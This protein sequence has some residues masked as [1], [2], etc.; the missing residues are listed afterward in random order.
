MPV[1]DILYKWKG[2]YRTSPALIK[3]TLGTAYAFLPMRVRYGSFLQDYRKLLEASQWWSKEMHEEYQTKQLMALIVHAYENTPYYKDLF[4]NMGIKPYE[5][6]I[7]LIWEKIPL[8]NKDD[9]R[10]NSQKLV[11]QNLAGNLISAN[12]GGSTGEPLKLYWEKGRTRSL[13]RAFMWRQWEWAGFKYGSK[14]AVIRG[15]TVKEP[16]FHYDPI[17]KHLFINA[18][19]LT[20]K[21]MYAIV[22]KLNQFCPKSIQAYPSTLTIFAL[23]MKENKVRLKPSLKVLLCGSENLYPAQKDLFAETF[24]VRVYNWY[25]HGESCCMAGYCDKAD[26]YHV[27][28]E[29]G[30]VELVNESGK[31]VE[32]KEGNVGEIVA[33][34]FINS[35]MPLIRYRTGDIAMVGP[36]RCVCGRNYPLLKKIQGRKQEYVITSDGRA[37]SLTGL[38][39]GQHWHAFTKITKLQFEQREAGNVLIR[40]IKRDNYTQ[41]DENEIQAKIAS[42]TNNSLAVSFDYVDCIEPTP[43]GKHIFVKQML[44]NITEW[45]GQVNEIDAN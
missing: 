12:T 7:K 17:D 6:D 2:Q 10:S 36:D 34:G 20:S 45:S 23:W 28:S 27:Y 42:C 14:T 19:N 40:I 41:D 8:L 25:G 30:L 32:W 1:E 16:L 5:K 29:Y 18:Y 22:E 13:E 3:R 26:L 38:V 35:A 9:V 44:T 21:N 15:Q 24:G 11:A 31:K 43:R 4:N 33:T 37:I 39:F